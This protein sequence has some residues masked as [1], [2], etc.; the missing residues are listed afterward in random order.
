[1][2]SCNVKKNSY[3]GENNG[4]VERTNAMRK[5]LNSYIGK[6]EM[7]VFIVGSIIGR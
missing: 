7:T 4:N 3:V 1:M 6:E 2:W 5:F